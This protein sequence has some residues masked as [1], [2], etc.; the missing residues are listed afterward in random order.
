MRHGG[1]PPSARCRTLR[2]QSG[3][4]RPRTLGPS[5]PTFGHSSPGPCH[6]LPWAS[7]VCHGGPLS[8]RPPAPRDG[9]FSESAAK[10]ASASRSWRPRPCATA[11]S[12]LP[13]AAG[14]STPTF[15]HSSA[16]PCHSLPW[17]SAVRHGGPFYGRPPTPGVRGHNRRRK[18]PGHC[19]LLSAANSW[20]LFPAPLAGLAR[21][22]QRAPRAGGPRHSSHAPEPRSVARSRLRRL[23]LSSSADNGFLSS[24]PTVCGAAESGGPLPPGT[25]ARKYGRKT[26]PSAVRANPPERKV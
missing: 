21:A 4:R 26:R 5:T 1:L 19:A 6:S 10:T 14:P 17:A 25:T 13:P 18:S 22:C 2:R 11:G 3:G 24:D 8:C 7:A 15:G 23:L 12:L 20:L 16:G 9:R